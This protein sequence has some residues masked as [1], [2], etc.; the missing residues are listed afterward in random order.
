[1]SDNFFTHA[2]KIFDSFM[3]NQALGL[4]DPH[5]N[6]LQSEIIELT[7]KLCHIKLTSKSQQSLET[8]QSIDKLWSPIVSES[9]SDSWGLNPKTLQYGNFRI[10][11]EK[12]YGQPLEF[13]KNL[14]TPNL[15]KHIIF[16]PIED[17]ISQ[18]QMTT[19]ND[20]PQNQMTPKMI[21]L[22]IK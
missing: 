8:V 5:S 22:K 2:I 11:Y 19:K 1:M 18:N 3:R 15:S 14:E 9:K 6:E 12:V 21:D 16:N 20:R 7:K 17:N 4:Y 13:D 10:L